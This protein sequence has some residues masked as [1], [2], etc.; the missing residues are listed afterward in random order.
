MSTSKAFK[1]QWE[2]HL[3]E[4]AAFWRQRQI[5]KAQEAREAKARKK[6]RKTP[7]Q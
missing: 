3:R 6:V 5:Q 2:L 7:L 1:R 4:R